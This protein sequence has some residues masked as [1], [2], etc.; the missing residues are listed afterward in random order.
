MLHSILGNCGTRLK[1]Y[2]AM[3]NWATIQQA[4]MIEP[5]RTKLGNFSA[6]DI[7]FLTFDLMSALPL[8]FYHITQIGNNDKCSANFFFDD[9]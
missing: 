5:Q 4:L 6:I 2:F 9:S 8:F 3:T 1:I 7:S